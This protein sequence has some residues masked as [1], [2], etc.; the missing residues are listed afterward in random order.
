MSTVPELKQT[1]RHYQVF[2]IA[3]S[4]VIGGGI[5]NNNATA[6]ELSGPDGLILSIVTM[7][8]IAI[9]VGE[10]VSEL[11]QQFPAPN[12][13][14]EYVR[15]FVDKDIGWVVGIAYWYSMAAVFA[16][17]SLA[18]AQLSM[19]WGLNQTWQTLTFYVFV[20]IALLGL[21]M[22]GVH[23]F[24]IIETIGGA[25]K[26]CL[27]SGV[28][29][30]LYVFAAQSQLARSGPINDGFQNKA[31]YANDHHIATCY[32]IPYVALSFIGIEIVAVT[33]FEAKY[34]RDLR[35]PS[36]Y[37]AWAVSLLYLL[38]T[39]GEVL[40]TSWNNPLLPTIYNG[41]RSNTTQVAK[42]TSRN[43]VINATSTYGNSNMASFLNGCLLFSVISSANTSLYVSSRTLYGLA[44]GVPRTNWVGR[45][46]HRLS[47]VVP[48]T[49]VPGPALVVSAGAF[50]WLPFLQLKEGYAIADLNEIIAVS[51]SVVGLIVWASLCVAYIRYHKW[52][53]ICKKD[54][55]RDSNFKHFSR[56]CEQYKAHTLLDW[57]QPWIA[58][59]GLTGCIL[60]FAFTSAAWWD[61][62]VTFS[63]VA[64]AY[65]AH[66]ILLGAFLIFKA[67]NWTRPGG[68]WVK[69][70]PDFTQLIRT[71]DTLRW[72]KQ[73]EKTLGDTEL[74]TRPRDDSV[75]SSF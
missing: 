66:V 58:Y 20:P 11:V 61:T 22:V 60:V 35:W 65:A 53:K 2:F 33:G 46:I 63:K 55:E 47:L 14:M 36:R 52:I 9:C 57:A 51:A 64:V 69:L 67:I 72:L 50:V 12:A 27:V 3:L 19:Y 4:G 30:M 62:P 39:M 45:Q 26:V 56:G 37:I 24:G 25:L 34:T 74:V 13:I 17:Q 6:L 10:C 5:F 8:I 29:I 44:M 23:T 75:L 73:D 48:R 71:L 70:D 18:A 40:T 7:G 1:L 49:G 21:N 15:A 54:L 16:V 38:C 42:G 31:G 41:T 28:S 68:G 59:I 43:I 32:A